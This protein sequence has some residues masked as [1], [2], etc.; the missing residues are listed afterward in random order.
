M[1]RLLS[2]PAPLL[3][4]VGPNPQHR[5]LALRLAHDV[6]VHH[7]L[8]STIVSA[9]E[10]LMR[11]AREG[12]EGNIVTIGTPYENTFSDWLIRQK[13]IQGSYRPVVYASR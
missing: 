4:V 1:I 12:E 13:R 7:R 3:F 6:L 11:V 9:E 10:A 5:Q 2:S 8:D